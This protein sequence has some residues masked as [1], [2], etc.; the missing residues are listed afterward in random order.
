MN[1]FVFILLLCNKRLQNVLYRF[2]I[3][4]C[5]DKNHIYDFY[6]NRKDSFVKDE[7][8]ELIKNPNW[9][10]NASRAI[11][12]ASSENDFAEKAA[13]AAQQYAAEMKSLLK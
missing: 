3:K 2:Y 4:Y 11:I 8:E 12:F 5:N 6:K 9:L 1:G 13:I 10:V 7:I